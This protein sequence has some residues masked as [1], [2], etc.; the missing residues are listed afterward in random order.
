MS[1]RSSCCSPGRRSARRRRSARP[2]PARARVRPDHDMVRLPGGAFV[3]GSDAGEG[4]P[5][6]GEAPAHKVRLSPYAIDACAVTNEQ[7]AAFVD[8]TGYVTDAERYGW[9]F[10]FHLLLPDDFPPTRAVACAPWWRQVEGAWWKHPEGPQSA[11]AD[12][13]DHPVVHVSWNDA[14]AYARWAGLRLPTEAEWEH[15]ARGGLAGA[16]YAW[17]DELTPDGEH[18]CNIWQGTFPTANSCDDGYLA[19]APARSFAANGHGLYNTAGNVW[20]WCGDWFSPTYYQSA[21]RT[22]PKGPV[23]GTQRVIRG[24][25]YLCH[26]SYCNRYR[27][28]ARSQ[29]EPAASTGHMGFRCARDG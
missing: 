9:S 25:S 23:S 17:G 6:D 7:F 11:I 10:V 8:A 14:A 18:C 20:E 27:V 2:R 19:T 24:G 21:R 4:F 13:L 22:D 28:A 16:R 26:A 29:N 12:R 3:M 5:G 15:A 1:K